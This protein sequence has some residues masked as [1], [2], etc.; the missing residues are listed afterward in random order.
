MW[1]QLCCQEALQ[2]EKY[3]EVQEA[4]VLWKA[5][6][7]GDQDLPKDMT[8]HCTNF[9]G[10]FEMRYQELLDNQPV[11]TEKARLIATHSEHSSGWQTAVPIKDLGLKLD[12]RSFQLAVRLHLGMS[13]CHPNKCGSCGLMVDTTARHG[14]S[15]IRAKVTRP[16]QCKSNLWVDK[17]ALFS[18]H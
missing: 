12:D 18:V 1:L 4:L 5:Q 7:N 16:R 10:F 11:P 8:V 6:F 17:C 2:W 13:L 14:L 3:T 9:M 15:C